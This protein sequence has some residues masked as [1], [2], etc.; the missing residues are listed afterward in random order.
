M[1]ILY[2]DTHSLFY[3]QRYLNS[4]A[5]LS[6]AYDEWKAKPSVSLLKSIKPDY[7]GIESL[8]RTAIEAGFRLYPLGTQY[9]RSVLI[10]YGL[11][12]EE[13]LAHDVT[14]S[15]R[16]GDNDPI[17]RMIAHASKLN[18]KWYICGDY[19]PIELVDAYKDR[20]FSSSFGKGVTAELLSQIR[21]LAGL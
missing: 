20:C 7:V 14:L 15:I 16:M 13:E 17:R 2:F 9:S 19:G 18:A 8:K 10:E 6:L 1:K 21:A 3:S 12:T 5:K 4:N 11:F